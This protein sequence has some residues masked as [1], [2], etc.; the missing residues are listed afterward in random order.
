MGNI[1]YKTINSCLYPIQKV[2]GKHIVTI[3]GLNQ[4]E[5]SLLQISFVDE[6]SSQCGFCTPGFLISLTGYLLNSRKFDKNEAINA[7]AGNIC[8]CT[9]Y[10]SILRSLEKIGS[11]FSEINT[12]ALIT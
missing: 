5:L 12:E 4:D 2:N 7:I 8:R 1:K 11:T 6:G 9:G 3:E 10:H